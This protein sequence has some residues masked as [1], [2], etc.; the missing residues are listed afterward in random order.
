[1]DDFPEKYSVLNFYCNLALHSRIHKYP[2]KVADMLQR[3]LAG[4]DYSNSIINFMD[5][6][7]QL[8]D[9]LIEHNIPKL[10]YRI[11]E[12]NKLLNA[13]YSDTPITLKVVDYEV[14]VDSNGSIGFSKMH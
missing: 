8:E 11:V 1:M 7:H 10:Q 12:F 4:T 2:K 14:K 9:F 6:H 3:V 5:F 13:I